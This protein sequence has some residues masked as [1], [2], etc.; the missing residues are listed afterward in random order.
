MPVQKND[1]IANLDLGSGRL[2]DTR[3]SFDFAPSKADSLIVYDD[4]SKQSLNFEEIKVTLHDLREASAYDAPETM[5]YMEVEW[6][7]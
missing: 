7:Y 1:P 6:T 5:D 4:L 2:T 3:D